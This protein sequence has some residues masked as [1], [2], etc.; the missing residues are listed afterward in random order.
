MSNRM[1]KGLIP[2]VLLSHRNTPYKVTS[3]GYSARHDR[4]KQEYRDFQG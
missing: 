3:E 4:Q 1:K 2:R